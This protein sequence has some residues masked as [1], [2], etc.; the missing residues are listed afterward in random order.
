M[1]CSVLLLVT[2]PG[3]PDTD[4][5]LRDLR[6]PKREVRVQAAKLLVVNPP[7]TKQIEVMRALRQALADGDAEV[8]LHAARALLRLKPGSALAIQELIKASKSPKSPTCWWGNLEAASEL[9]GTPEKAYA[10]PVFVRTLK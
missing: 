1:L 4:E 6:S 8:R 3:D 9:V 7:R 2:L 10:V 5:Y